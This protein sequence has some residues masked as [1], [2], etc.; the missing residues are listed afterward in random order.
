MRQVTIDSPALSR[1]ATGPYRSRSETVESGVTTTNVIKTPIESAARI[2]GYQIGTRC[3]KRVS[4]DSPGQWNANSL[5]LGMR[6]IFGGSLGFHSQRRGISE[7]AALNSMN[8]NPSPD[9]AR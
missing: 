5:G 8:L 9:Y 6:S 1:L 7:M 3:Y 2:P 4:V